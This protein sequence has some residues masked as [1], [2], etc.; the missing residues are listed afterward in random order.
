[1]TEQTAPRY[2][3][4]VEELLEEIDMINNPLKWPLPILPVKR[5]KEDGQPEFG[6]IH[7]PFLA[8][9]RLTDGDVKSYASVEALVRVGGW[10]VD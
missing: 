4:T 5:L 8:R 10:V 9:I 7:A 1:M 2:H 3:R 6:E